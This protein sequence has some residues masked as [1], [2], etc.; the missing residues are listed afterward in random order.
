MS[1]GLAMAERWLVTF[2]NQPGFDVVDW[3]NDPAP[4]G[5]ALSAKL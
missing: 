5:L 2:F 1:V 4:L 3:R